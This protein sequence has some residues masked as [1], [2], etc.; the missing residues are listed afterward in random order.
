MIDI[1]WASAE[2]EQRGAWWD[3]GII[4]ALFAGTLWPVPGMPEFSHH[5]GWPEQLPDGAVV[6]M[7]GR[8][9]APHVRWVNGW[10]RRLS[11]CLLILTGD[12]AGEFPWDALALPERSALWVQG[13]TDLHHPARDHLPLGSGWPPWYPGLLPV[14]CP[15]KSLSGFLAAQDTHQRRHECFAA[16]DSTNVRCFPS[17]GFTQGL[18]KEDYAQ[19]MVMA[20]TAPCPSGPESPDSF[21][22]YEALEAGAIPIVDTIT[23]KH[24]HPGYWTY[25]W[26]QPPPFPEVNDWDAYPAILAELDWPGD[27]NRS[28]A[29]WV[30]YKRNLGWKL[31]TTLEVI[32]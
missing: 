1:I 16:L 15:T 14:E 11:W 13:A 26:G 31:K 4:E 24:T 25:L 17:H 12:E 27:A 30:A 22:V 20:R 23:P 18:S 10:L 21:R 32:A 19:G 5:E 3:A 9:N 28:S 6:V 7:P 2:D 29:A 8:H